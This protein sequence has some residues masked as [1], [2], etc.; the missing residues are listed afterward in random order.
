[1]PATVIFNI[2]WILQALTVRDPLVPAL[3]AQPPVAAARAALT[4]QYHRCSKVRQAGRNPTKQLQSRNPPVPRLAAVVPR[5]VPKPALVVP[6][7][8]LRQPAVKKLPR[9][10]NQV[11]QSVQKWLKIRLKTVQVTVKLTVWVKL[12]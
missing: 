12:N 7:T 1:M 4:L 8:G 11:Q 2:S 10:V 5:L 9:T 6:S 3:A